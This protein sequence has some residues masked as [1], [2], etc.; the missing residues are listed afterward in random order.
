MKK[1]CGLRIADSGLPAG[2]AVFLF[3]ILI[4]LVIGGSPADAQVITLKS[5]QK[6]ETLGV[7]RDG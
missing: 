1:N 2:R 3:V 5:G 7:R 4:V 6:I